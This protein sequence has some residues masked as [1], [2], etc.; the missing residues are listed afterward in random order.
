MSKLDYVDELPDDG[1][2]TYAPLLK[3]IRE[4]GVTGRWVAIKAYD[5][6][7]SANDAANRLRRKHPDFTFAARVGTVYAQY[8]GGE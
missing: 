6:H 1:R 4:D 3:A 2:A 8:I 7:L 5:K